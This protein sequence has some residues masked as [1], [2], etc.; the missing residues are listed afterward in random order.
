LGYTS[1]PGL[2]SPN[3]TWETATTSNIGFNLAFLENRLQFDLD[4]FE[5][6]TDNMIGPSEPVPGVLGSSVPKSNN[7]SLR[8]RGWESSIKWNHNIR[9][10][11]FSYFVTFN[12][13]DAKTVVTEY[14]NPTG[15]ITDW[16][17]G[18]EIGEIWGYTANELFKSQ[19]EVNAYLEKVDLSYIFSTW[20]PGDLKYED[21]N[22]DDKVDVGAR[23]L[24]DHGDLSVIGNST[25]RYQW[26]ISAGLNYKNFDFS[27]LIKGTAKRDYFPEGA[28][29]ENYVFWGIRNWLFTALQSEHLDYFRDQPGDKYTGL[30][31][32]D[33][34]INLDAFWPRPYLATNQNAKNRQNSTRY[35]VDASYIRLQNVQL[36]YNLPAN[37]LGKIGLKQVR[38]FVSGENL[39]TMTDFLK[40]ID[41]IAISGGGNRV[42]MTYGADN[43]YSFGI[44]ATF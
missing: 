18:K 12:L 13:Y 39:F 41:P 17:S 10:S 1:T 44:N 26:G 35:L 19:E 14:L 8:T 43:I 15:L 21:T 30:H 36:G 23:S 31:E 33:A 2:V 38:V 6:N 29:S 5:R 7:A 24:D 9:H 42:G 37:I 28:T 32:G 16:Y 3:L 20:N 4:I 22:G 40:G 11:D 27:F 25:P 34:N